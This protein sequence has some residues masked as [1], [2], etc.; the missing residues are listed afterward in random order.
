MTATNYRM[1]RR[2]ILIGAAA[3]LICRTSYCSGRKSNAGA[4]LANTVFEP[5]VFESVGTILST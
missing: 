3:S 1:T 5:G 2:N 4:R